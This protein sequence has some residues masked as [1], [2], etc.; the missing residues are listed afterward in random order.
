MLIG[1]CTFVQ[2]IEICV[3]LLKLAEKKR[4]FTPI[5]VL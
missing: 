2:M 1:C 3:K 4:K 5:I